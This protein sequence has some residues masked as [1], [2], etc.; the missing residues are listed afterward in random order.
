MG[1]MMAS[2]HSQDLDYLK[3]RL[4][5]P[6]TDAGGLR[7]DGYIP[8][9][10]APRNKRLEAGQLVPVIDKRYTLAETA[11]ALRYLGSGHARGKVVIAVG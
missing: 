11:D 7:S 6:T 8:D 2:I 9:G 3:E 1:S 5:A 4:E 10:D